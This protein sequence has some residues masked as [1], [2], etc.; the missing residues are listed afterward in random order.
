MLL[1]SI[2]WFGSLAPIK[3]E[4]VGK[5]SMVIAGVLQ[6]L[7]AGMVSG[8]H[9]SVLTR[10]PPSNIVPLPSRSGAAEPAWSP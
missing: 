2:L 3:S 6:M 5:M 1:P 9:I 4:T 10:Q 7:P 8:H